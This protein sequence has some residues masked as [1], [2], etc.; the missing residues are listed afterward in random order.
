MNYFMSF[1]GTLTLVILPHTHSCQ[2]YSR[3][4]HSCHTMVALVKL[5]L[6]IPYTLISYSYSLI[7]NSQSLTVIVFLI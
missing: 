3:Q 6:V 2:N 7:S 4:T 5:I 1:I